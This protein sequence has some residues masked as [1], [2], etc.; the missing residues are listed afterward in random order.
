MPVALPPATGR[1]FPGSRSGPQPV[2]KTVHV[3][4]CF[5]WRDDWCLGEQVFVR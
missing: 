3:D 2:W 4:R 5:L 1:L